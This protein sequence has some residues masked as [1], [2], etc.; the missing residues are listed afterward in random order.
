M[1]NQIP[2][3]RHTK[4]KKP[5]RV[6]YRLVNHEDHNDFIK[7]LWGHGEWRGWRHYEK[8]AHAERGMADQKRAE[9]N[10]WA[11]N[12]LGVLLEWRVVEK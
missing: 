3:P 11:N 7:G 6:Q 12:K 10:R 8:K 2:K 1:I 9:E 4:R 5:W